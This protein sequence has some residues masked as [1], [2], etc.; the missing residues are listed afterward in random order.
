MPR[1]G[2]DGAWQRTDSWNRV[3]NGDWVHEPGNWEQAS[4]R[5]LAR[6]KQFMTNL[7]QFDPQ[8]YMTNLQNPQA[9]MKPFP[10]FKPFSPFRKKRGF[11]STVKHRVRKAVGLSASSR[12]SQ[13]F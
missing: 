7:H 6:H 9:K 12:K 3:N 8:Q 10:Y 1:K 4:S 2:G 5:T 11:M 13:F